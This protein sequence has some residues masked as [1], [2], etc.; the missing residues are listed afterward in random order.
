MRGSSSQT[1]RT[2]T[3]VT[4]F[5]GS[6][7]SSTNFSRQKKSGAANLNKSFSHLNETNTSSQIGEVSPYVERTPP[8]PKTEL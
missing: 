2:S 1:F 8:Q 3:T 6:P 5:K 4:Q 7:S